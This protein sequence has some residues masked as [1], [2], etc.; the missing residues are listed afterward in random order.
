[1]ELKF[2]LDSLP[3]AA[4]AFVGN[5]GPRR[6]FAFYGDMGAGKTTF[7]AE[8]CRILGADDDFGSPTFSILNEYEDRNGNPIYHFDFYRLEDPMEALDIGVE[9][10]FESGGLCLME[11]PENIGSLLPEETVEVCLSVNDDGSR[12]ISF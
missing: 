6:L 8:V 2:T 11:W 9:G 7:I 1:M 10:Y 3:E 5:I 4:R 12:T